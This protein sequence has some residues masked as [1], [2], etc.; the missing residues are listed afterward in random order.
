MLTLYRGV[1]FDD[2]ESGFKE[3]D[4]EPHKVAYFHSPSNT[5]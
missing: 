1:D 2:P 5:Y 4:K 3:E